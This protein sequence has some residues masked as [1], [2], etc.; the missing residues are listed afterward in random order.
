MQLHPQE[1]HAQS[2]IPTQNQKQYTVLLT[3][4][5]GRERDEWEMAS[6]PLLIRLYLPVFWE[7]HSHSTIM[8]TSCGTELGLHDL[9]GYVPNPRE[10]WRSMI[11]IVNKEKEH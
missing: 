10:S 3:A 7:D 2:L 6:R 8:W 1:G 11:Q 4:S 9:C 5:Q